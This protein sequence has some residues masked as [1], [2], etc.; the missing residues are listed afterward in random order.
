MKQM[1][2]LKYRRKNSIWGKYY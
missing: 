1:S 2:S